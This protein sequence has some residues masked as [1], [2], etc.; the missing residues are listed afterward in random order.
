V[1][2]GIVKLVRL[3]SLTVPLEPNARNVRHKKSNLLTV[4][5]KPVR[6]R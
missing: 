2:R 4:P 3:T 1:V 5:N 6:A